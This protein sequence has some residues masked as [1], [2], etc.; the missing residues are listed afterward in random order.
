MTATK[1]I[2]LALALALGSATA[3]AGGYGESGKPAGRTDATAEATVVK[4][5]KHNEQL[6]TFAKVVRKAGMEDML[7][8]QGPFTV[9]AP[10]DAAFAALPAGTLERLLEPGNRAELEQLVSYHVIAGKVPAERAAEL[11]QTRTL[12]GESVDFR[13]SYGNLTGIDD[14]GVVMADMR[15][16]NGI[17]HIIDRVILPEAVS[18]PLAAN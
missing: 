3:L 16:D 14:A 12:Q 6:S 9:L 11:G 18:L 13:T 15:T 5:A 1:P 7:T 2:A 10:T 8:G 17:V 4:A